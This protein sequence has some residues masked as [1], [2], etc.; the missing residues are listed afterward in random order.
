MDVRDAARLIAPGVSG[1]VWAD[2]GAGRGTFTTALAAVLGP[3][4]H[5][6]AVERDAGA[7]DALEKL[8]RRRARNEHALIEVVHADFAATPLPL[9][10]LDGILMAN[11]L[12]YV[13]DAD[14]APLLARLA[15]GI[16]KDGT[17]LVVEYDNR[18]RSRW[19]PFPIAF[20]RLA[21][22]ARDAELS[23]PELI[24]RRESAFGGTMYAAVLRLDAFPH[25][26]LFGN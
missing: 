14:Q 15:H 7:V 6:Y 5:V 16:A 2:L 26:A 12:H 9:K 19:V 24:G 22:I 13:A 10:D 3:S 20:D 23:G 1:R 4:G 25:P 21:S 11:S 18:P 17:L 8:A